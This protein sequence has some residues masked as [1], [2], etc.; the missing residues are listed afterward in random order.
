VG[1]QTRGARLEA[2]RAARPPGQYLPWAVIAAIIVLT[3]W[4]YAPVVHFTFVNYFDDRDF[5]TGNPGIAG[6]LTWASLRY[7]VSDQAYYAT[8]GPLTWLSHLI[9]IE[10]YGL[11]APGHHVTSVVIHLINVVLLFVLLRRLTGAWAPSA[12]VSAL[13]AVHPLHV[14]SVAW[15]SARKDVLSA[16]FWFAALLQYHAFVVTRRRRAY[17]F[18]LLFCAAGLLSKPIVAMLPLTMLALD[19]WPLNRVEGGRP[20][21]PQFGRLVVE[22]IPFAALGAVALL[23]VLQS[24]VA[25]GAIATIEP[26]PLTLRLNNA[27][28]SYAEYLA[29]TVW[30]VGLSAFYPY[31]WEISATTTALA[32]GALVALSAFAVIRFRRQPSLLAGWL[33]YLGTLLPV[34]GI[35]R[36]GGH[37]MAD[38]LTYVP[39]IGIFIALTWSAV[40][41]AGRRRIP[42]VASAAVAAA[43]VLTLGIVAR[44]QAWTWQDDE[45]LWRHALAVDP[46]NGR[47][48][49]NLAALLTEQARVRE[50]LPYYREALRLEPN[51]PK[52]HNNFGL[53]LLREGDRDGAIAQFR[54]A[55]RIDPDYGRAHANLADQLAAGG[56]YDEAFAHYR[57][58]IDLDSRSGLARMNMA[59]TLA[60]IG[61]LD[62]AVRLAGEAVAREPSRA[63][64][65]FTTAMML[66]V[67]GRRADAIRELEEVLRI[68]P[69]HAEARRELAAIR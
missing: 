23:L 54:E 35:V 32:T 19:L 8:G 59:V 20:W 49:A 43:V 40:A 5:I 56:Q 66:K 41:V 47:A 68:Q 6:G 39:L 14:E 10:L 45:T 24:Q 58:A 28:V 36:I 67:L 65:R 55:V 18:A 34:V 69:D 13:F 30:P 2:S 51:E 60:E 11:N 38:R 50:A 12:F 53:A 7:I 64:W 48:D 42:V 31:R 15:V 37:A 3:A 62:E 52:T 46:Q 16:A 25:R 57:R 33:W 27:L 22:K 17:V 26:A 21:W 61:R 63:D 44:A 29:K 9:D 4:I 1:R